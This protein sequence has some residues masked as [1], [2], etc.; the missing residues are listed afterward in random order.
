MSKEKNKE[1]VVRDISTIACASAMIPFSIALAFIG[2]YE[3]ALLGI[4]LVRLMLMG[5]KNEDGKH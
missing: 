4:I 2:E 5:N 1:S 3:C